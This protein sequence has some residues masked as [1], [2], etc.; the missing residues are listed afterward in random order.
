M[1]YVLHSPIV[2]LGF[3]DKKCGEIVYNL[4][5]YKSNIKLQMH[6]VRNKYFTIAQSYSAWI[7]FIQVFF[8]NLSS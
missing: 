1:I 3:C 7:S 6:F 4:S 5:S 2:L 8:L